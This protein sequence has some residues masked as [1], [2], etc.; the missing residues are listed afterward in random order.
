MTPQEILSPTFDPAL[1]TG[2]R[3][4]RHLPFGEYQ[5]LPG[6]NASLLKQPTSYEML[7]YAVGMAA[8]DEHERMLAE[9][10]GDSC[11]TVL[12][13]VEQTAPRTIPA[14]FEES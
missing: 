6:A 8:L 12:E 1:L 9:R 13:K 5:R 4:L 14:V 7:S 2:G 11:A 3:I 10:S